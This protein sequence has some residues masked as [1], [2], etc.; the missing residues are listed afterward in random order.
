MSTSSLLQRLDP[1]VDPITGLVGSNFSSSNRRKVETFRPAGAIVAGEWVAL[2]H[3]QSGADRAL[4]V[5]PQDTAAPDLNLVVGVALI[6]TA[7]LDDG[8]VGIPCVVG[9][10]HY[11]ADIL[12]G[13]TTTMAA[14]TLLA[15]GTTA[16]TA[17]AKT[18]ATERTIGVLLA[19]AVNAAGSPAVIQADVM[20]AQ[21]WG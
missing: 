21:L 5:K 3:S 4:Y 16:G 11:Q 8:E 2:D 7:D 6:G 17:I 10:Y 9:G 19:D 14:G 20:V 1:V 12:V 15:A 18:A 13:A